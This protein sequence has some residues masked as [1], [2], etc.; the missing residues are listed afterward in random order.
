MTASVRLAQLL[1]SRLCHDLVGP[2]AAIAA[3]LELLADPATDDNATRTLLADSSRRMARYLDFY[4]LAF[5]R[6]GG[7]VTLSLGEAR[8]AASGLLAGGRVTLD[9]TDDA[10][11]AAAPADRVRLAA[12]LVLLAVEALPRGGTVHVRRHGTGGWQVEAAGRGAALDEDAEAAITTG[13]DGEDMTARTVPA[14][15][16]GR[17]AAVAGLSVTVQADAADR[18]CLTAAPADQD[19]SAGQSSG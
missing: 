10:E 6:R 2:S 19:R 11:V 3:G 15:Y 1:C 16:A 12:C 18:V 17:L 5:G 8:D 9:W 13:A 7:A 4:R 14:W